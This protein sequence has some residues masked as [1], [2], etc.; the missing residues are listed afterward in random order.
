MTS[1]AQSI[2]IYDNIKISLILA[3]PKCGLLF[4]P[5]NITKILYIPAQKGRRH[6]GNFV[7]KILLVKTDLRLNVTNKFNAKDDLEFVLLYRYILW[8]TL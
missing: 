8:D 2:F 3:S 6:F 1:Y 4:C 5:F 7:S